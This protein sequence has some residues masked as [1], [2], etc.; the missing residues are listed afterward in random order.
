ML[1]RLVQCSRALAL[2]PKSSVSVTAV[3]HGHYPSQVEVH[4]AALATTDNLPVPSGSWQEY[5]NKK[6][7]KYNMQVAINLL[8]MIATFIAMERV[9]IFEP[10]KHPSYKSVEIDWSKPMEVT[11]D[12]D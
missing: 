12:E 6:N 8:A 3:R 10:L 7:S 11:P 4:K 1:P 5:Y 2:I 9:G